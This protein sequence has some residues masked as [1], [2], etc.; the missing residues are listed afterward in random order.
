M[1][2][3]IY[4]VFTKALPDDDFT[5]FRYQIQ[6]V[7]YSGNWYRKETLLAG[8]EEEIMMKKRTLGKLAALTAVL[9]MT[10]AALAGC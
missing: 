9:T 5:E 3:R 4:I 10:G 6:S 1:L 2:L 8:N 7:M